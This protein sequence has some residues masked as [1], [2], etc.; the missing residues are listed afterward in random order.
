MAVPVELFAGTSCA[1][2]SVTLIGKVV[3]FAENWKTVKAKMMASGVFRKALI[4][5]VNF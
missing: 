3:P 1:P 5:T 2:V 4:M